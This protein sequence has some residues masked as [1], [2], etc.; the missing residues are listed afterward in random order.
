MAARLSVPTRSHNTRPGTSQPAD[1]GMPVAAPLVSC[2][3]VLDGASSTACYDTA[4]AG[5]RPGPGISRRAAV[6]RRPASQRRPPHP[7][8]SR[9]RHPFT[10]PTAAPT[11]SRRP[12][13]RASDLPRITPALAH[14]SL[15]ASAATSTRWVDTQALVRARSEA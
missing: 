5:Q 3:V 14:P 15:R 2:S 13:E 7:V 11:K 1:R 8:E 10:M 6:R 12:L 4:S 9:D